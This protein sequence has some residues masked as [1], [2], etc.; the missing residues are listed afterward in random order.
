MEGHVIFFGDGP[1]VKWFDLVSLGNHP[2]ICVDLFPFHEDFDKLNVRLRIWRRFF[3]VCQ[4]SILD[5]S[6]ERT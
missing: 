1:S 6:S 4:R 5:K 2:A 3:L